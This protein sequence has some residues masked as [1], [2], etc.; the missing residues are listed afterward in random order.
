MTPQIAVGHFGFWR[1]NID[2][3]DLP[4]TADDLPV[5]FLFFPVGSRFFIWGSDKAASDLVA[6]EINT[7]GYGD[8]APVV[9]FSTVV[10]V[11]FSPFISQNKKR[12]PV[13]ICPFLHH[14]R[15]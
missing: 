15:Y 7:C 3:F 11:Y 2:T 5:Q 6:A 12:Q 13:S 9:P 10:I 1:I 4:L 8:M 14:L